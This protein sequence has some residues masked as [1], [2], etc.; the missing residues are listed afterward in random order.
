MVQR[1]Y[2]KA[3][4][5]KKC[6][7]FNWAHKPLCENYRD[8]VLRVGHIYIC[9]SCSCAYLGVG[10][11]LLL[12]F[13][14]SQL[15]YDYNM[16]IAGTLLLTTLPFSHPFIYKKLG[17]R[18]RDLLRLFLGVLL[19]VWAHLLF[20]GNLL[21]AFGFFVLLL[22]FWRSYYK[23]RAKRKLDDCFACAE[24]S[25]EQICSGYRLQAECIREYEEL[26]TDYLL[27][28]GHRPDVLK[29]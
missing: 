16:Q 28:T 21:F 25:K 27:Q 26:A 10:V 12:V 15:F 24:Y 9:R 18:I 4:W 14:F 22:L 20:T 7:S 17:R 8:D 6:Y 1:I 2:L 11:A 13:F 19:V 5:L 3:L 23:K 29:Q